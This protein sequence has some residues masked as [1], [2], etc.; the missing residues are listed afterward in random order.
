MSVQEAG[1]VDPLDRLSPQDLMA[2]WPDLVGWPQDIGALAILDGPP[3]TGD[4]LGLDA[5]RAVINDR[6]QSVPRL[7]QVIHVPRRGLGLPVWVDAQ[8]FD[9]QDHVQ[10]VDVAPPGGEV[11]LL[12]VME[13]LRRRPLDRSRPLW[14]LWLLPGLQRGRVGLYLKMHH[15]VADGVAGVG[16]LMAFLDTAPRVPSSGSGKPWLPAPLP[17]NK[18]IRADN[19]RRRS[20]AWRQAI[21]G[22]R[23]PA[24]VVRLCSAALAVGRHG[25][26]Q[27]RIARTSINRRIGSDRRFAIVR[28]SLDEVTNVAHRH[29]A[30]VNDVLLAV[31]TAG[32]RELLSA[33][34]EA[35]DGI[36]LRAMVPVS[37]HRDDA[38]HGNLLGSMLVPLPVGVGE[39]D[40]RLRLIAAETVGRKRRVGPRRVPV[41]RSTR[42]QRGMLR[43]LARQRAYNTYVAD[44]PGPTAPLYLAGVRLLEVF[45]VVALMGNL[46]VGVGAFSYDGQL[47][48][49]VVGD[50]DGC[51]DLDVF[52]QG[53]RAELNAL[54]CPTAGRSA[55]D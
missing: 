8:D 27:G 26:A 24:G 34:G 50:R 42:A 2:F 3:G 7:R 5:V 52:L 32:L 12:A 13:Q 31:V 55:A 36:T 14:G 1:Q 19:R 37:M 15:A 48:I 20:L 35:V 40:R 4:G 17:T 11:E 10:Q 39:S 33:R 25:L 45:A 22:V 47:N 54:G 41:L 30:K 9:L 46:T 43:L 16:L 38:R 53:A 29:E 44:I 6:L 49:T 18:Q 28:T 21:A 51:P 23:H